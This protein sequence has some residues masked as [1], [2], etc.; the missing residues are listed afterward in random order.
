ML[1]VIDLPNPRAMGERSNTHGFAATGF[2]GTGF[3]A[4]GFAATGF[5]ATEEAMGVARAH[6]CLRGLPGGLYQSYLI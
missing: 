2:A 4:T 5:A 6:P 3:A 1:A